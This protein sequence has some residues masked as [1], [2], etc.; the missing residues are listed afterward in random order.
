MREAA[1]AA[2]Q[3]FI[4]AFNAQ[5]HEA[6]ADTLNY[7]STY[8]PTIKPRKPRKRCCPVTGLP[9]KYMDPL[10]GT[11]YATSQA[12]RIIRNKYISEGEQK[13]EKRL[14]QLS[15]WLEEKKRKKLE[16]KSY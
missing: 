10:T 15:N 13:C 6:L 7:P 11:P 16:A 5:D 2:M 14:L 3:G 9:A 1:V 12:F 8:F 4:D